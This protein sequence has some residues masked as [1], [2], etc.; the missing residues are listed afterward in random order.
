[1]SQ[2]PNVYK[3][4]VTVREQEA[5]EWRT[6]WKTYSFD[7]LK[8]LF[9]P[10]HITT[11]LVE[12]IE[13]LRTSEREGWRYADEL[14]AERVHLL[15]LLEEARPAIYDHAC[16]DALCAQIDAAI[17]GATDQPSA[18][19][20]CRSE[21]SVILRSIRGDIEAAYNGLDYLTSIHVATAADPNGGRQLAIDAAEIKGRLLQHM[22]RI[23]AAVTTVT[24]TGATND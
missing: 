5:T 17:A 19:L 4:T 22:K 13:R 12:E 6:D 15:A 16:N 20:R 24:V 21:A 11:L 7:E 8:E 1:M 3:D 18:S 23:D 2:K 14:E 10:G 9:G